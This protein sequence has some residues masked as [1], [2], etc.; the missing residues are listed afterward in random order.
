VL[1]TTRFFCSDCHVTEHRVVFIKD[2]RETVDHKVE[3]SRLEER[4]VGS[5]R[6]YSEMGAGSRRMAA[7]ALFQIDASI[8]GAIALA[9]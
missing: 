7:A 3:L 6:R 1:S 5:Q 2:D 9:G 8:I 4:Q